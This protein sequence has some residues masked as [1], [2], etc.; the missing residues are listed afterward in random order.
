MTTRHFDRYKHLWSAFHDGSP[1][2]EV[3]A[4][5][6]D[7][8]ACAFLLS[9]MSSCM[10]CSSL[11]RS[12]HRPYRPSSLCLL[13]CAHARTTPGATK[14]G[15]ASQRLPR[16]RRRRL[17]AQAAGRTPSPSSKDDAASFL[18]ATLS[19]SRRGRLPRVRPADPYHVI[20]L[21]QRRR[22]LC[23]GDNRHPKKTPPRGRGSFV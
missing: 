19:R 22:R 20:S 1:T 12:T 7:V 13:R 8:V 14:R 4:Y 11:D 16:R 23:K 21:S 2:M 18:S 5:A 3:P 15:S 9:Q 6:L 17:S 10:W